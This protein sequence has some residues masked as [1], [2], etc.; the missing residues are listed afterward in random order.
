[1]KISIVTISFNQAKYLRQCID[2]VLSQK[3]VEL[4]YI[5]VDPGSTDGSREII[6]SYGDKLIKVFEDD[7]GPAEG[8][9][10]GFSRATGD[11]YGFLNSD[12]Y[13]LDNSLK[14]I[15]EYFRRNKNFSIVTGCG[16][17]LMS[18]KIE[19]IIP[20]KLN[21]FN[22]LYRSATIFQQAT[23]FKKDIYDRSCHFNESNRTCWDYEIFLDMIG[24]GVKHNIIGSEIAV[25]RVHQDSITG[26]GRANIAYENDL[27]RIF[28]RYKKR[29]WTKFDTAVSCVI[30]GYKYIYNLLYCIFKKI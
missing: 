9:N 25:F 16:Y 20:S 6:E 5:I 12:D 23:F 19:K 3:D 24:L 13:F 14:L 28:T 17:V 11:I 7:S 26:S 18:D 22:L 1:M 29:R 2:S 8:L 4:E 15:V 10:N 30:R 27:D 21:Y